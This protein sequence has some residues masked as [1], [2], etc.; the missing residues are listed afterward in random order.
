MLFIEQHSI[1]AIFRN[2]NIFSNSFFQWCVSANPAD[3][4]RLENNDMHLGWIK[5][6]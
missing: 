3:S 5:Y 2:W 6:W 4:D 1:L